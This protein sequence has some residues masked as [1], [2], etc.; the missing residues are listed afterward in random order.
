MNKYMQMAYI[1]AYSNK[2][3]NYNY[4]LTVKTRYIDAMYG[5]GSGWQS[6]IH[7]HI[8]LLIKHLNNR[9]QSSSSSSSLDFIRDEI[10]YLLPTLVSNQGIDIQEF[11]IT[12]N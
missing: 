7:K 9:T 5:N 3:N 12:Q 8:T 11:N 1:H 2:I 10:K 4:C 6:I